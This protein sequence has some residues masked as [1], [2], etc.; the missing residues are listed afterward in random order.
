V[1]SRTELETVIYGTSIPPELWNT[2]IDEID[3]N[4]DGQVMIY[5]L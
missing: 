2:I 1:I 4:K 3:V 5:C